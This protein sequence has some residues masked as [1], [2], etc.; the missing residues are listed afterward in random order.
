MRA[1]C[2]RTAVE[3]CRVTF[4]TRA[5]FGSDMP[6]LSIGV[7]WGRAIGWVCKPEVTGSIPV[8]SNDENPLETAG[9]LFSM[10]RGGATRPLTHLNARVSLGR[11]RSA[12]EDRGERAFV[13]AADHS[14]SPAPERKAPAAKRFRARVDDGRDSGSRTA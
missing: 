6:I 3:P 8:R 14:V 7:R 2:E 12:R 9:F 5:S 4:G 1:R 13:T 10:S 11:S